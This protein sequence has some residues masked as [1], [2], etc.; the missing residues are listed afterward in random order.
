MIELHPGKHHTAGARIS[1]QQWKAA[2]NSARKII[3]FPVMKHR[4]ENLP[5]FHGVT[6]IY[7]NQGQIS[8]ELGGFVL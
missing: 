1:S 7:H 6:F 4:N 8:F 2:T 3:Q 5:W